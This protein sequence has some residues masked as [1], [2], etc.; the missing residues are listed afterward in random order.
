[1]TV[2]FDI[3]SIIFMMIAIT[4]GSLIGSMV[5]GWL[6]FAGGIIGTVLVGF[7]TY[8]IYCFLRGQKIVLW[9]G[10]IFSV[11]VW[12]ANMIGGAVTGA[13][14]FGGGL[15]GLAMTA[16]ILSFLWGY[17]GKGTSTKSKT[18]RKRR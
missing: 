6:G 1:M 3:M 13:T 4:L 5:A 14:G 2:K 12:L 17:F 15:I 18:R 9:S 11:M 16:L 7:I 10:V 8:A